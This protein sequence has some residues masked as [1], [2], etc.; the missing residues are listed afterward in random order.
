MGHLVGGGGMMV[1]LAIGLLTTILCAPRVC[2]DTG[3]IKTL[4]NPIYIVKV[5]G[6][7][8]HYMDR[9]ARR[10]VLPIK[11]HCVTHL[12]SCW[13]SEWNYTP[14]PHHVSGI[15]VVLWSLWGVFPVGPLHVS[16]TQSLS[17]FVSLLWSFSVG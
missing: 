15:F 5:N 3:T 8:V 7:V 11:I 4:E 12:F 10:N 14:S 13:V 16:T 9:C 17:K 6:N 1:I 2:S